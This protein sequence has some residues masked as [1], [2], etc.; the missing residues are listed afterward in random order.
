L[1]NQWLERLHTFLEL[2]PKHLGALGGGRKKLTGKI[3]IVYANLV[4]M[5]ADV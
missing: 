1:L 2:P 4:R 3:D 5:W